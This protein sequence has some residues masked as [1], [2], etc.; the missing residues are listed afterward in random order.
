MTHDLRLKLGLFALALSAF[1]FQWW[2][3][4]AINRAAW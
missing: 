4:G 3:L 1:C 2:L